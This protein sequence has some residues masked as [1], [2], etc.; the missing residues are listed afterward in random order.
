MLFAGRIEAYKGVFDLLDIAKRFA[1]A[2]KTAIEFDLCGTGSAIDELKR[3]VE[4]VRLPGRFRV[5]GHCDRTK[6]SQMF[7]DCHVLIVPTTTEFPEGFNQVVVEG[8]LAGRPVITSSVCP[9]LDYVRDAVVEVPPD[10]VSAYH[11]AILRLHDDAELYEQK[12]AA[13]VAL[14]GQFYDP[15]RGWAA[16]LLTALGRNQAT[17]DE[18]N[19]RYEGVK[20]PVESAGQVG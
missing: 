7:R 18:A 3:Q 13:S 5:H 12:R 20:E 11:D 8:I 6:M 2:G 9:A 10:D 17:T 19:R 16:A 1:S 4:E 14:Q 15:R